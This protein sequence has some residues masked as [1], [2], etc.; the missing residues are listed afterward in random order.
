MVFNVIIKS[1]NRLYAAPA[2]KGLSVFIMLYSLSQVR[3]CLFL[4]GRVQTQNVT[5]YVIR[6][7]RRR[8]TIIVYQKYKVGSQTYINQSINQSIN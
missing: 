2:V 5:S 3:V 4:P 6:F 7:V 8:K 1:E